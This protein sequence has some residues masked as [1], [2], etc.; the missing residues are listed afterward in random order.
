MGR[1]AVV[2]AGQP[3][4]LALERVERVGVVPDDP[5][6]RRRGRHRGDR[7]DHVVRIGDPG[8][9]A[10][11]RHA[12]HALHVRV[13][14]REARDFVHVG[15]V[16]AHRDVQHLDAVALEHGEVAVV[17][18][19]GTKELDRHR[20]PGATPRIP[21]GHTHQHRLHNDVVHPLEAGVA[22]DEDQVGIDAQNLAEDRTQLRQTTGIS[23]V[24]PAVRAVG[25]G[26]VLPRHCRQQAV[27][28]G[29]LLRRRLAAGHV[30]AQTSRLSRRIAGPRRLDYCRVDSRHAPTPPP[31]TP[32]RR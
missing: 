24:V 6:V 9:V 13:R 15:A 25:G 28:A 22:A 21:A 8:R 30:E 7:L 26:I 18:G 16:V 3:I 5:E 14:T 27:R 19:T 10:V 4:R 17:A 23:A 20:S 32:R 29:K 11:A 31:R 12:E 1:T 2:E